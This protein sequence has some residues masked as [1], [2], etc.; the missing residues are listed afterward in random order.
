[1]VAKTSL[2]GDAATVERCDAVRPILDALRRDYAFELERISD[3][4]ASSPRAE[5][6][7][8]DRV[9]V[10]FTVSNASDRRVPRDNGLGSIDAWIDPLTANRQGRLLRDGSSFDI[11]TQ[12]TL[13][14]PHLAVR[15]SPRFFY[16]AR[17]DGSSTTRGSLQDIQAR[18]LVR[19]L[20]VQVGREYL[21]WG[22]GSDVGLLS[23]NNSPPLDLIEIANDTTFR[24]PSVFRHLGYARVTAFYADLGP[25]QD[26]P[27]AY[28]AGYKLSF[29][30]SPSFEYGATVYTKAGGRGSPSASLTSRIL[31]LFPFINRSAYDN[32]IGTGNQDAFS[33]R[34][35]GLDARRRF[36]GLRG[37]EL[38]GE[39]LMNDFD[40][41]RL[42][43]VL[44]EDAGHVFGFVVPNIGSSEAWT[45]RS[46]FHHTGIRYY[47][48]AQYTSGQTVRQVLIGDP[49]GPNALGS[50]LE[51]RRD[52]DPRRSISFQSAWEWRSDDQYIGF[53]KPGGSIGFQRTQ[54]LP[55]ETRL[56]GIL[57]F[58]SQSPLEGFGGIAQVGLERTTNVNFSVG[59]N[60][61]GALGRIGIEYRF[62]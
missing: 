38:F 24:I 27:G 41:R 1:M 5:T 16:Q 20:A 25:Q 55:K 45:L 3:S 13:E 43:S 46:E 60:K 10:D 61:I 50:Y 28:L 37:F 44:W 8:L 52:L 7:A 17:P 21:V 22:Q 42:G 18:L 12:H 30:P 58:A 56:R 34:Y 54:V 19:N 51:L 15:I 32:L 29:S 47:E 48:H 9:D 39:L 36:A 26:Q 4:A 11:E 49:L 33:D 31:D 57:T 62:P 23:S 53:Q 2:D 59:Q 40:V 14:T 6:R 35:A